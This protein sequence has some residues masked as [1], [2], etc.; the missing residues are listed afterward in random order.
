[1]LKESINKNYN[2]IK[3]LE[4]CRNRYLDYI[5]KNSSISNYDYLIVMDVDGVNNKIAFLK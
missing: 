1:M 5:K 4:I 2:R 3:N